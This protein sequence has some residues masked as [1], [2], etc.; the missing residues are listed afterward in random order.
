LGSGRLGKARFEIAE[1]RGIAA[2]IITAAK[3]IVGRAHHGRIGE[4]GL[5]PAARARPGD[6]E[7]AIGLREKRDRQR[8]LEAGIVDLAL[9]ESAAAVVRGLL[10]RPPTGMNWPFLARTITSY[11]GAAA[12]R[13]LTGRRPTTRSSVAVWILP[14]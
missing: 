3:A 1:G 2:I 5:G 4:T 14:M 13:E 12:L 10:P 6:V 7:R 9:K 11:L 8:G